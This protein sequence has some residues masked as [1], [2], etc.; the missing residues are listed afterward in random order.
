[1]DSIIVSPGKYIQGSGSI[2]NIAKYAN[3][4]SLVI[5][6]EF[7]MGITKDL[8][9]ESYTSQQVNV[10]F[11]L[12]NG[13]CSKIEID[14]LTSKISQYGSEMIVGI[15]GGKTLDTAKAMAHYQGLPVVIV[16]TIASTDAPCSALSV[17][18]TEDGVFDQYLLLPSN[19]N[20]VLMDTDIISNAPTRLLVA[21]MGDALATYFEARAAKTAQATN[22]LGGLTTN[23]ALTLARLCYDTLIEQGYLAKAAADADVSTKALENIVEANTY[24]SGVGFES[25]GLAAAHA[26]HNGLTLLE[27]CHHLYH[28]EKVAFGT[29]TQ[30]ILENAPTDEIEEVLNFCHSVGLPTCLADMGVKQIDKDKLYEVAKLATAEGE[31]IH[32]MPFI[33]T[34]ESVLAAILTADKIGSLD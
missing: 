5:A 30:L 25:G 17:L 2:K 19:P 12:F 7:V 3:K 15:G 13:E 32:N 24:L 28:G 11:E 23:A 1:M 21:G 20:V 9:L 18:Y 14:R 8:V 16:P 31:T 4:R 33:V 22:M 6:D 27:E 29:I 10:D 26:I 34:A